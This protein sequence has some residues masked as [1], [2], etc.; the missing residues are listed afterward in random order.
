MPFRWKSKRFLGNVDLSV[1][2]NIFLLTS[3]LRESHV[4]RHSESSHSEE[5]LVVGSDASVCACACDATVRR[6]L[7]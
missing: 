1:F 4:N 6:L 5:S 2:V 7:L 3:D